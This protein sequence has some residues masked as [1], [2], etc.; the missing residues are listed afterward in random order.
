MTEPEF[1]FQE[2]D[3]DPCHVYLFRVR[4]W[5]PVGVGEKSDIIVECFGGGWLILIETVL[6]W[7]VLNNKDY[8]ISVLIVSILYNF[9]CSSTI[10]KYYLDN[11]RLTCKTN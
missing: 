6:I 3:Y 2:E 9:M 5:N 10:S 8:K 4:A 11:E 1:L 7:S